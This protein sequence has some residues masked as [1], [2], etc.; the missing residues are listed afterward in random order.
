V[1]KQHTF[2]GAVAVEYTSTLRD[3][4]EYFKLYG[5]WEVFFATPYCHVALV[6]AALSWKFWLSPSW[7]DA[8][9]SILPALLG[10]ALAAYALL[11][12]FGDE[13]FRGFLAVRR[14]RKEVVDPIE[15][16]ILLRISAIYLHFVIVQIVALLIAVIAHAHILGSAIGI[17]GPRTGCTFHAAMVV[18]NIFAFIGYFAFCLSITTSAN[19]ALN[20]FHATKWYVKYRRDRGDAPP[21]SAAP[22]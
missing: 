4:A 7:S 16:S 9:L 17:L 2:S 1:P 8:P 12:S 5:S 19:A 15:D 11:F 21:P 22:S 6:I 20:L 10:F 13:T 14:S 3:L 18:R